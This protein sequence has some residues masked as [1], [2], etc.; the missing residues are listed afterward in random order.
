[1][2]SYLRCDLGLDFQ[3]LIIVVMDFSYIPKYVKDPRSIPNDVNLLKELRVSNW[4][5]RNM[6]EVKCGAL[7]HPLG[8]R[9]L[10][11]LL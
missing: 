6:L 7:K 9:C 8:I 3:N 2:V 1:M 10:K 4:R 11:I 5:E